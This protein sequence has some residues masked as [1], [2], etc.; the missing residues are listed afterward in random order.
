MIVFS[1]KYNIII[2]LQTKA[3]LSHLFD[4]LLMSLAV[5]ISHYKR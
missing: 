2:Q 3:I 4:E 1:I 5:V